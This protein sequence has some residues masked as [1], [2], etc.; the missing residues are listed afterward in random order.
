TPAM[1]AG[2]RS[3]GPS[4]SDIAQGRSAGMPAFGALLPD[5]TIW[6]LVAYVQS[7]S[8]APDHDFGTTTSAAPE[9]QPIKQVPAGQADS[10]TP[11]KDIEP[12][13]PNGEKSGVGVQRPDAPLPPDVQRPAEPPP[14]AQ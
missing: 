10:P 7:L 6:E 12:M 9:P 4:R 1:P 5:R 2:C 8:D 11:W 13:P 3:P 14:V